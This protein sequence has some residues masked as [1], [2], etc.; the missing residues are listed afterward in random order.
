MKR[1]MNA[2]AALLICAAWAS[3]QVCTVDEAPEIRG[4]M[5]GM[6]RKA[7]LANFPGTDPINMFNRQELSRMRG[8]SGLE[9]L[10]FR[11]NNDTLILDQLEL[12]Y[13][14]LSGGI[15]RLTLRVG[16][17]L[18]LPQDA[19]KVN[20]DKAEMQCLKFTVT[21]DAKVNAYTITDIEGQ[22]YWDRMREA[23]EKRGQ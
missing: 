7:F 1:I 15:D 21:A 4:L 18:G 11:I 17:E 16:R 14:G 22:K 8:F 13:A 9:M 19:W 12:R 23:A 10:A 20:G 3:A 6:K 5:L 2:M